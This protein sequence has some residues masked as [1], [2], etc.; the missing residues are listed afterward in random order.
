MQPK[1]IHKNTL[2]ASGQEHTEFSIIR[3]HMRHYSGMT[4]YVGHMTFQR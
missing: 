1:W 3:E 4:Q 2:E